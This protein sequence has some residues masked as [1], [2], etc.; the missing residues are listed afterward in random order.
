[1]KL[2]HILVFSFFFSGVFGQLSKLNETCDGAIELVNG[3]VVV[4]TIGFG[5]ISNVPDCSYLTT[6]I[7]KGLWYTFTGNNKIINLNII[8]ENLYSTKTSI[9]EGS[10]DSLVCYVGNSAKFLSITGKQ[11]FIFVESVNWYIQLEAPYE[12]S[13]TEM[14][15]EPFA[16]CDTAPILNCNESYSFDFK[17]SLL[18][19]NLPGCGTYGPAGF[20][21]FS[22]DGQT[23][24]FNFTTADL[25]GY[26]LLFFEHDSCENAICTGIRYLQPKMSFSTSPNKSYLLAMVNY[27]DF[28]AP[29]IDFNISCEIDTISQN[30]D[31]AVEVECGE[32]YEIGSNQNG[33]P[34]V[35]NNSSLSSWFKIIG[36]DTQYKWSFSSS[37]SCKINIFKSING[38]NELV[39]SVTKDGVASYT[40]LT[41]DAQ[42]ETNYYIEFVHYSYDVIRFSVQCSDDIQT[43]TSCESAIDIKCGQTINIYNNINNRQ[44]Y[45][46]PYIGGLWYRLIGN[47]SIYRISNADNNN[48]SL[49]GRIFKEDCDSLQPLPSAL[50]SFQDNQGNIYLKVKKGESYLIR[51][52]VDNYNFSDYD[53]EVSCL[54]SFGNNAICIDADSLF[55]GKEVKLFYQQIIDLSEDYCTNAKSMWFNF[56]GNGETLTIPLNGIPGRCDFYEGA[57]DDLTCLYTIYTG[58]SDINFKTEIGKQ[59]AMKLSLDYQPDFTWSDYVTCSNETLNDNCFRSLD[60]NCSTDQLSLNFIHA[61]FDPFEDIECAEP[62]YGLWYKIEGNGSINHFSHDGNYFL[63]MILFNTDSC[64]NLTC[65]ENQAY[66]RLKFYAEIGKSYLVL[67]NTPRSDT[68]TLVNVQ[69]DELGQNNTCANAVQVDCGAS[70]DVDFGSVGYDTTYLGLGYSSLWFKFEGNDSLV[71]LTKE[72]NQ[73]LYYGYQIFVDNCDS[74]IFSSYFDPLSSQFYQNPLSFFAQSGSTYYVKMVSI[75]N[76]SHNFSTTCTAVKAGDLCSSATPVACG[77]TYELNTMDFSVDYLG[78]NNAVFNGSWLV[79]TGEDA[80]LDISF[81]VGLTFKLFESDGSCDQMVERDLKSFGF[82]TFNFYAQKDKK[83]Y[84]LIGYSYENLVESEGAISFQCQ[85]ATA[86]SAICIEAKE[87]QCG[88]IVSSNN[89][90]ETKSS[91]GNCAPEIAG[92]WFTFEGDGNVWTFFMTIKNYSLGS[93]QAYIGS[94]S[95]DSL[96]C[97]EAFDNYTDWQS[98]QNRTSFSFETKMNEIYFLKLANYQ[99]EPFD[100]ELKTVCTSTSINDACSRSLQV[101]CGDVWQGFI[102]DTNNETA[103]NPC[104]DIF[105]GHYFEIVGTGEYFLMTLDEYSG[106][107]GLKVSVIENAC[108]NGRCLYQGTLDGQIYKT[109][110]FE[111]KQGRTYIVKIGT[112]QKDVVYKIKTKCASKPENLSCENAQY[113]NCLDTFDLNLQTPLGYSG[114][115]PCFNTYSTAF[116]YFLP[117]TDSLFELEILDKTEETIYLEVVK[118]SCNNFTCIES[119]NN[120]DKRLAFF[121][122]NDDDNYLVIHGDIQTVNQLKL[123]LSCVDRPINDNCSEA[124]SISCGDIIEG[125]THLSTLS[126]QSSTCFASYQNDV[127]YK[128]TGDGQ[129]I[130]FLV[131]NLNAVINFSIYEADNCDSTLICKLSSDFGYSESGTTIDF[132]GEV[133]KHYFLQMSSNYFSSPSL[134]TISLHC[135]ESVSNDL[136]DGAIMLASETA[137]NF[138]NATTDAFYN[139]GSCSQKAEYGIWYYFDGNDS[140]AQVSSNVNYNDNLY[141]ILFSGDCTSL[142]CESNGQ[143]YN[144]EV[145]KFKTEKGKRYYLLLY[146]PY[147]FS[148][149][150]YIVKLKYYAPQINDNCDGAKEVICGDNLEFNSDFFS[151][152]SISTCAEDR[153]SVWFNIKG[154]QNEDKV[155]NIMSDFPNKDFIL[156]VYRR[157]D[158]ICEFVKYF[159]PNTEN[160]LSFIA[161]KNQDYLIKINFDDGLENTNF[162]IKTSCSELELKNISVKTA[163]N[164]SCKKYIIDDQKIVQQVELV[165]FPYFKRQLYYKFK[166]D[167]SAFKFKGPY[168]PNLLYTIKTNE[169]CNNLY[170]LNGGDFEFM[171]EVDKE[172]FFVVLV[173][174]NHYG[175]IEF[176]IDYKCFSNIE[177][178]SPI[179]FDVNISPNPFID[180]ILLEIKT[181]KS[182]YATIKILDLAGASIWSERF[183]LSGDDMTTIALDDIKNI[184]PSMYKIQIVTSEFVREFKVIKIR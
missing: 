16:L 51:F 32:T 113:I 39:R 88:D 74:M 176:D 132:V 33:F 135:S 43:N 177:G 178:L 93:F 57:C 103:D 171:T 44:N 172:Y 8:N 18:P 47:D 138:E 151:K 161:R 164:I 160:R 98:S 97:L 179:G 148:P 180:K 129:K 5:Q 71:T 64:G 50:L 111:A 137:I 70:F 167:G 82:Y 63:K 59:Y 131:T 159:Y 94:G 91:F 169:D 124:I 143:F 181:D 23:R 10:C 48:Y 145:L 119:L 136:C 38:C 110:L 21:R 58:A 121:T 77:S 150:N 95:C 69:C 60:L 89:L 37:P 40:S 109:L 2:F 141:Y 15:I 53:L 96:V 144:P 127:W 174:E 46:N 175:P 66:D 72:S 25:Y 34:D 166:G 100:I 184:P 75:Q 86:N 81:P 168:L 36:S 85:D 62:G 108:E 61:A 128:F 154:D 165:C 45:Q 42:N 84:F 54:A 65:I 1:M 83:Y 3:Q 99:N 78:E 7:S 27:Q 73:D 107:S 116:W 163:E 123:K 19:S 117:K 92:D 125:G 126:Q 157:C 6:R 9:F 106:T 80:Y 153:S 26:Y 12:L 56:A 52:D 134:F 147:V 133:D 146:K 55:C 79:F 156:Q 182:Q 170:E 31:K 104:G 41:I 76:G 139:L 158:T 115:V 20:F 112:D 152:D 149:N 67:F 13:F 24:E 14:D 162:S 87:I 17:Q 35:N 183:Y 29:I 114:D 11:Y 122:Q 120:N 30:C 4:D 28:V 90:K 140:L 101:N 68:E 102:E 155:L 105:S 173:S 118:G 130:S 142:S 49:Q 22:G